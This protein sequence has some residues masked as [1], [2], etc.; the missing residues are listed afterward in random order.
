MSNAREYIA[1]VGF[2]VHAQKLLT[3]EANP[4]GTE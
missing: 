4:N 2:C 1:E 3:E